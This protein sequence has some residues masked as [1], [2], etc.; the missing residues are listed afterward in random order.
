MTTWD[1]LDEDYVAQTEGRRKRPG[2]GRT[3]TKKRKRDV[4]DDRGRRQARGKHKAAKGEEE[5]G[6]LGFDAVSAEEIGPWTHQPSL[7]R[8]RSRAHTTIHYTRAS[9]PESESTETGDEDEQS[10]KKTRLIA[11]LKLRNRRVTLRYILNPATELAP[12]PTR[13]PYR[14]SRARTPLTVSS[15]STAVDTIFSPTSATFAPPTPITLPSPTKPNPLRLSGPVKTKTGLERHNAKRDIIE[16]NPRAETVR[17]H[18]DIKIRHVLTLPFMGMQSIVGAAF[19]MG[20]R[21][22]EENQR[23]REKALEKR[24]KTERGDRTEDWVYGR[25]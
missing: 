22:A 9:A 6:R 7:W 19:E 23:K 3:P 16:I 17:M 8:Q 10:W 12:T 18:V 13:E 20:V 25:R 21:N 15:E 24:M 1:E 5:E 11:T 4:G 2:Q 14:Y